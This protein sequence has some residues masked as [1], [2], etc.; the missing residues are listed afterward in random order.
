MTTIARQ[1]RAE[2]TA[3]EAKLW[4]H[5]RNRN[6]QGYKFR[7]QQ[8][9]GPFVAD[10]YC[11]EG[12]LVVEVDGMIHLRQRTADQERDAILQGLG[13]KILRVEAARVETDIDSVLR[14]IESTLTP[15][16][17]PIG[18]GVTGRSG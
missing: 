16:P 11:D 3:S 6:M 13:L 18:R 9:I 2:S 1:L 8:P 15:G 4:R 17:S 7:R 14:E 12:S 5:L 10:F